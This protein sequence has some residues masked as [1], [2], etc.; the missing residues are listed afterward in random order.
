MGIFVP[1][2]SSKTQLLGIQKT[3]VGDFGK[4]ADIVSRDPDAALSAF[5]QS[6]AVCCEICHKTPLKKL[7]Q[8][9]GG[10]SGLRLGSPSLVSLDELGFEFIDLAIDFFLEHG[11]KLK[12]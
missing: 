2:Q 3:I 8:K 12:N 10:G 11:D 6:A 5:R 1:F 7:R 9:K 4:I